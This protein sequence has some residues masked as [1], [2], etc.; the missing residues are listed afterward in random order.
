MPKDWTPG[1]VTLSVRT[2]LGLLVAAGAVYGAYL[3]VQ[4]YEGQVKALQEQVAIANTRTASLERA[5]VEL[6][7]ELRT[8][9]VITY[10]G[11]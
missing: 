6:T 5:V 2:A 7:M 1:M 11:R 10:A 3:K 9:G 8:R 4:S